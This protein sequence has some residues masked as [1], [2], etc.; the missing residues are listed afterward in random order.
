MKINTITLSKL[1]YEALEKKCA[2]YDV[3]INSGTEIVTLSLLD[4]EEMVQRISDLELLIANLTEKITLLKNGRSSKTSSTPPAHDYAKKYQKSLR[5]KSGLKSGGQIGHKG[6]TLE[7]SVIPD[8]VIPHYPQNTC[9]NCGG[10]L[11][12]AIFEQESRKQEI[13]VPIPIVPKAVEHQLFSCKCPHCGKKS[14]GEYPEKLKANVQYHPDVM[15]FV[16]YLSV[17]QYMPFQRITHLLKHGYGVFLSEGTIHNMLCALAKKA[18]GFIYPEIKRRIEC[19]P[20]VGSDETG[21]KIHQAPNQATGEEIKQK[22]GWMWTFQSDTLTYLTVSFSRGFDTVHDLFIN[23]F[24]TA[25]YVVSVR[26]LCKQP[27]MI[28][29]I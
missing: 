19:A 3:L 6:S 4:Y 24:P 17:Y 5:I 2:A 16:G 1:E 15:A 13:V 9:L 18:E 12:G 25:V 26:K 20:V 27:I 28:R 22:R 29:C 14:Q 8:E 7:F 10:E 11:S 23:G 21:M